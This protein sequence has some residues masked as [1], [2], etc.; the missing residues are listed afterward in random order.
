MMKL[1]SGRLGK[2]ASALGILVLLVGTVAVFSVGGA[3]A[4]NASH[5]AAARMSTQKG[6]LAGTYNLYMGGSSQDQLILDADGTWT[7]PGWCDGGSWLK[8]G[9]TIALSDQD[10]GSGYPAGATWMA[11]VDGKNLG[12]KAKPGQFSAPGSGTSTWYAIK[13]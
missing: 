10:C 7:W 9:K 5:G 3:S 8:L 1:V 11:T 6:G 13:A 12:S 4:R 2:A